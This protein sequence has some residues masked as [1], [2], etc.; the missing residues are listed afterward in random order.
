[1]YFSHCKN[2]LVVLLFLCATVFGAEPLLR[3]ARVVRVIDGDTIECVVELASDKELGYAV[4]ITTKARLYGIDAPDTK[5]GKDKK[6]ASTNNLKKLKKSS[7]ALPD[8]ENAS[9]ERHLADDVRALPRRSNMQALNRDA[10]AG[11][12]Q[13]EW[14]GTRSRF[15]HEDGQTMAAMAGGKECFPMADREFNRGQRA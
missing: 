15:F 9:F 2:A 13:G 12:R 7:F 5:D 6:L 11:R 3:S 4:S 1:M 10:L 8:E 14:I